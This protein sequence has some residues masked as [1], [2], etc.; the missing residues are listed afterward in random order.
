MT[1]KDVRVLAGLAIPN[2]VLV[3]DACQIVNISRLSRDICR[4]T[5]GLPVVV[6]LV[7]I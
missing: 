1:T 7:G 5:G 4:L 2:F 6:R 3:R